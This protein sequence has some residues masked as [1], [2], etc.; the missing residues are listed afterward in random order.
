MIQVP[1]ES[2]NLFTITKE[3]TYSIFYQSE[4][5]HLLNGKRMLGK[6]KRKDNRDNIYK[7]IKR[8]FFNNA[9]INKLNA[10]LSI[11]GSRDYFRK[12]P[13]FFAAD[14][15]KRR[16]KE[17]LDMTLLEIFKKYELYKFEN[18]EGLSNYK[19][20]LKVVQSEEI[21]ENER[22]KRILN[23]TFSELYTEYINSDEFNINEIKRL[24]QKKMGDDYIER[25]KNLS[26][27]LIKFFAN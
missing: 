20:N 17:I 2:I 23:K 6:R 1:Y 14:V 26:K 27:N 19:H 25:Y 9:L 22:I 4:E 15:T 5:I 10:E 24:K 8:N 12:F 7:K 21:N 18:A 13:Q 3:E 11:S 16:N